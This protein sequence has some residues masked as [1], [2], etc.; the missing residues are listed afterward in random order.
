MFVSPEYKKNKIAYRVIIRS[1]PQLLKQP[2]TGY[3]LHIADNQR[4]FSADNQFSV[5]IKITPLLNKQTP[6]SKILHYFE[7][8]Y[9]RSLP[10]P[11]D[12]KVS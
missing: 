2:S 10:T 9:V 7:Q 3:T 8:K 11:I 4:N 6:L 1:R 5:A 12:P